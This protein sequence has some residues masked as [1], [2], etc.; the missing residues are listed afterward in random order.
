MTIVFIADDAPSDESAGGVERSFEKTRELERRIER[1]EEQAEAGPSREKDDR[2]SVGVSGKSAGVFKRK[3]V[4][5]AE[6]SP[7]KK[8]RMPQGPKAVQREGY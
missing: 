7:S 8:P 4:G 1:L 6:R 3:F 2:S 5:K